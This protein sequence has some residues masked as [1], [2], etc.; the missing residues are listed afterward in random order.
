MD[1]NQ[2]GSSVLVPKYMQTSSDR[3]EKKGKQKNQP[4]TQL[5]FLPH[6][7]PKQTKQSK[8]TKPA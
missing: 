1:D 3:L 6:K 7:K 2:C 5:P 8:P 4:K